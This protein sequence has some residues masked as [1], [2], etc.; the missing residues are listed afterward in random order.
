M[1]KT[2]LLTLARA[3]QRGETSASEELTRVLR[4]DFDATMRVLG[5]SAEEAEAARRQVDEGRADLAEMAA[6]AIK[7]RLSAKAAR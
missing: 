4:E 1:T 3:H 7:L 5:A 2:R 6:R